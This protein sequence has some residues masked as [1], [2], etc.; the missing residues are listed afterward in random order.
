MRNV[1]WGSDRD[2]DEWDA[3][4]RIIIRMIACVEL[5]SRR[6]HAPPGDLNKRI[7][8]EAETAKYKFLLKWK[9]VCALESDLGR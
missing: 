2:R 5:L 4:T 6:A 8:E 7:Y 9:F 3:P 1:A